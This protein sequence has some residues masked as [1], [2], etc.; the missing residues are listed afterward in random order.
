MP[1]TSSASIMYHRLSFNFYD[2]PSP[3]TVCQ[4]HVV[5]LFCFVMTEIPIES[6]NPSTNRS[7]PQPSTFIPLRTPPFPAQPCRIASLPSAATR[8]STRHCLCAL[9]GKASRPLPPSAAS[10]T[11]PSAA[12]ANGYPGSNG[13]AAFLPRSAQP[14]SQAAARPPSLAPV[15]PMGDDTPAEEP[16]SQQT[17]DDAACHQRRHHNKGDTAPLLES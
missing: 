2:L 7:V 17:G 16:P 9:T 6:S 5:L 4:L 8:T 13:R 12:V 1:L 15:Q 10:P 11:F 14:A 3:S